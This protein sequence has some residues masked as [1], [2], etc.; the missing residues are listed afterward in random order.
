MPVTALSPEVGERDHAQGLV[1][2]R[3]TLVEY[4]DFECPDCGR[5]YPVLKAVRK[6]LGPNLRFVFRHFPLPASHPHAAA[7]AEAAEAA[8]A[9][10]HFWEMHDR[11]YEHQAALEDDALRRHARKAGLDLDR[12]EREMRAHTYERRVRE[13]LT[14]GSAS[15]VHGTPA[16]FINGTRYDGPRDRSSLVAALARAAVAHPVS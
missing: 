8:G 4:G 15:H 14:S 12:F 2:A 1:D 16:L 7:A 6:A 5:A 9:Q 3:V 11:L 13:D 10:G